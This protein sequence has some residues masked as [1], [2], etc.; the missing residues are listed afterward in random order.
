MIGRK[1]FL[2]R[3]VGKG[4][5]LTAEA[6]DFHRLVRLDVKDVE[7]R[8]PGSHDDL[9]AIRCELG[10]VNGELLHVH[11]VQHWVCLIVHL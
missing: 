10:R 2:A 3:A 5:E 6:R 7:I 9:L 11:A 1:E 8:P 4:D